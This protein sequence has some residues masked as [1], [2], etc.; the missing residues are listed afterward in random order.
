MEDY[1]VEKPALN[2]PV[3]IVRALANRL[4]SASQDQ[5]CQE[6]ELDQLSWNQDHDQ[7]FK[8]KNQDRQIKQNK[9]ALSTVT[10]LSTPLVQTIK[11]ISALDKKMDRMSGKAR[12]QVP[13][14]QNLLWDRQTDSSKQ[15]GE[16]SEGA[17]TFKIPQWEWVEQTL[18]SLLRGRITVAGRNILDSVVCQGV[19]WRLATT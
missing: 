9:Y 13:L 2:V 6:Q 3:V 12:V 8:T 11:L 10:N 1:V 7:S 15:R 5:Q 18:Y 16:L 4:P 14:L 19:P 17:Q